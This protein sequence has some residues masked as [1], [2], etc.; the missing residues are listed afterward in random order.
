MRQVERI[1]APRVVLHIRLIQYDQELLAHKVLGQTVVS[2]HFY[3]HLMD[4]SIV[5]ILI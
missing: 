5:P 1:T 4:L 3:T 2:M